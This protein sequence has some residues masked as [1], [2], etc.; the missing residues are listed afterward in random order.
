[1]PHGDVMGFGGHSSQFRDQTPI[2]IFSLCLA[3]YATGFSSHGCLQASAGLVVTA[4]LDAEQI[5]GD[6]AVFS[7]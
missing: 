3:R 7:E 6:P 4:S 1:M 5:L 2:L